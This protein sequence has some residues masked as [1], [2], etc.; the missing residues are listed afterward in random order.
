MLHCARIG[1]FAAPRLTAAAP[2]LLT[3]RGRSLA[4]AMALVVAYV[5]R[6]SAA[7][8][9]SKASS[10][11]APRS[12]ATPS[13]SDALLAKGHAAL[14]SGDM[15]RALEHYREAYTRAP[16]FDTAAN[17]GLVELELG[18]RAAAATHL[19]A[20]LRDYPAAG[21][22]AQKKALLEKVAAASDELGRSTVSVKGRDGKRSD[23]AV[24]ELDGAKVGVVPLV[25]DVYAAPGKHRIGASLGGA[26]AVREVEL[27][28]G[29]A[30]EVALE[31]GPGAAS[32]STGGAPLGTGYL[33][34]IVSGSLLA[35]AALATGAAFV[36]SSATSRA[37]ADERIAALAVLQPNDP[38]NCNLRA[39]LC[40]QI[41]SL[42][43]DSD[44]ATIGAVVG[45]VA[46]A[47]LGGGTIAYGL[48][49]APGDAS[50]A[51]A[52]V[53]PWLGPSGAGV[54]FAAAF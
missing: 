7:V 46:G 44:A 11:A 35:T 27:K 41:L 29:E 9:E 15:Q 40:D 3:G 19:A 1:S 10:G 2:R 36:M 4:F 49:A 38:T 47:M 18:Q 20:A 37:A 48:L 30:K 52:T 50:S 54:G 13:A 8:E 24:V 26:A 31:L 43:G 33:A 28:A 16:R 39:G 45:F 14:A 51:S 25:V 42:Q 12:G 17:L 34:T 5:P 32:P 6:A 53:M 21:D 22:A 23:F